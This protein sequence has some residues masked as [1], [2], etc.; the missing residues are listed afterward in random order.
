[1][2][3]AGN[4]L[5]VDL[6]RGSIAGRM[7]LFAVPL[8]VGNMLQQLYNIADTVIVGRFVGPEA[9]AAVGAAYA[10]L[11]FLTSVMS[12]LSMGS[13]VLVSLRFGQG[14]TDLLKRTVAVSTAVIGAVSL[15]VTAAV[16]IWTDGIMELLC[17]PPEAAGPMGEYLAVVFC[18]IPLV[19]VY[20]HAAAV[21]RGVGDSAGPLA[22]LAVSVVLNVGLDFALVLWAGAGIRGAAVATLVSQGAAA[23]GIMLY[24][25]RRARGL[26][27]GRGDFVLRGEVLRDVFSYSGLTCAQQSVMNLGILAVQGIVN[28]FGVTVMAAFAAAV[29]VDSFAYMPL[30]D[31]GNA[32]S[33]F[34]AQNR[35][36]GCDDR[37]RRGMRT[38]FAVSAVFSLAVS[39][40]VVLLAPQLMSLFAQGE[41][42]IAAGAEYLRTEGAFY[43]GIGLLFLF[44]GYFRAAGYPGISLVLTVVS[45][46][47]RVVLAW[48]LSKMT[49]MGASG[50]W[51]SVPVG[52][53]AA[54]MVGFL[55]LWMTRR[56]RR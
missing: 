53:A 37:V 22:I 12:G 33:T 6:T 45:L 7:L 54:D 55:L 39:G 17:V 29:K 24:M 25:F 42:V 30:Q 46:G 47:L 18:G 26:L 10:L 15:A 1:M 35:G 56:R 13:G 27:P 43:W 51:W 32:F 40:A 19:F 14:R 49:P 5:K 16:C 48:Y 2:K 50:I 52:W 44:Y 3:A 28:S 34:V 31:F 9:L 4:I 8:F 38:A 23:A 11:V 20:N 36:A 41:E 21:L